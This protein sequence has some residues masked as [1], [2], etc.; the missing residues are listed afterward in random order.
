MLLINEVAITSSQPYQIM[1]DVSLVE[2]DCDE[3]FKHATLD[4]CEVLGSHVNE[5]V[6][7]F[8][9]LLVNVVHDLLVCPS[10]VESKFCVSGP[11]KLDSQDPNL[12]NT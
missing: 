2:M 3:S 11:Q 1:K 10:I 7:N 9:E 6:E 4:L 12:N 8:Q 5:H